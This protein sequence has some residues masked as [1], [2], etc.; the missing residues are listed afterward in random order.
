VARQRRDVLERCIEF[1]DVLI[2][3]VEHELR[4]GLI[5]AKLLLQARDAGTSVGAHNAEAQSASTRRHLLTLRLGALREAR[6]AQYWLEL[7][8]RRRLTDRPAQLMWLC[9]EASELV[10][11]HTT[12]VRKLR[13]W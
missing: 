7:I 3:F 9:T 1:S 6:E 12:I 8:R 4:R 11:I 5:P 13:G 2:D 10:A